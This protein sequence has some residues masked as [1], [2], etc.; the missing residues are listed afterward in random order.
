[1]TA[2][3]FDEW[4]ADIARSDARQELFTRVLGLP[5]EVG[6]SN[7]VPLSGLQAVAAA[8]ALA[9]GD[10]LVDLGCGRGGPGMWLARETGAELVGVDFSPEAIRQAVS[11]RALFGLEATASFQ[12]GSLQATG[13]PDR[14]A[15]AVVSID[16]IQFASDGVDAALEIRRILRPGGRVV[17][18]SWESRDPSD[19]AMSERIRRVDLAGWLTTAGFD[20]VAVEDRA[21]WHEV[22]RRLWEAALTVDAPDDPAM[23]STRAEAQRSLANHEKYRRLMARAVA[24]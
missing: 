23:A 10:T 9:E 12:V 11:R 3:Y 19:D 13:L 15:D 20:A 18:T 24:P 4:F 5:R 6:P 17:L 21:D 14:C 16:A 7:N 2:Q 22:T 8:L 1:M